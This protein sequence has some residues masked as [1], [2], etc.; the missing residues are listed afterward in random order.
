MKE[1]VER[2]L[3]ELRGEFDLGQKQLGSLEAR[4]TEL[5]GTLF[6]ISGAIQVL[7]DVLAEEARSS[8]DAPTTSG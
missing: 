3:K 2:R 1:N 8:G 4:V 6:R 5:R 7:E